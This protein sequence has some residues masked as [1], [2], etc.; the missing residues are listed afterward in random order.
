MPKSPKIT[1]IIP[2]YNRAETLRF[3]IESVLWQTFKD[4]EFWVIGDACTDHTE[5]VV[6]EFAQNTTKK[7]NWYNLPKNSGYQSEPINYALKIAKGEYIAY[8]NHD[9]IWLPNHLD[10]L[11]NHIE[12]TKSDFV[13][14]ILE[15]ILSF[16][17]PRADIAPLPY[18]PRTPEATAV[19]H[20]LD[21]VDKIGYWK[22]INETFSF[23]R[24]EYFRR[25]IY[26]KLKLSAVPALTCLKFLWD[27][28][29]Y[30]EAGSHAEYME[31]VKNDPNF[32]EKQLSM[33]LL[34]SQNELQTFKFKRLKM[35]FMD[36]IRIF[37]IKN[38]QI[39]PASLLFWE[40]PGKKIKIWRKSHRLED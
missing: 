22:G 10:V 28:T 31:M 26:K 39:D 8:L 7:I 15:W 27:E 5:E 3:A 37:V 40:G 36:A 18:M 21:I 30:G 33:L 4:F 2:T 14:S 20:R 25:L 32:A 23:P 24:V 16:D 29:S 6:K 17:Q 34:R 12:S 9:D 11:L 13:F 1:V 35:R 19:M 38:F